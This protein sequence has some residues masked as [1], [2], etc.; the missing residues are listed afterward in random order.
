MNRSRAGS[1]QAI[2]SGCIANFSGMDVIDECLRS[3]LQQEGHIPIEVLV[4]D[5]ASS[6]ESATYIR[7]TYPDVIPGLLKSVWKMDCA[8][9]WRGKSTRKGCF[10]TII[11]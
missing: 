4:H 3:V 10:L 9:H 8:A 1:D 5:D 2:V 7:N 6:D 11:P